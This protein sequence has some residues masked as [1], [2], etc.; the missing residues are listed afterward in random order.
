MTKLQ[1]STESSSPI[2]TRAVAA[3]LERNKLATALK[4]ATTQSG[5]TK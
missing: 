4:S 3:G 1:E 5:L 2:I